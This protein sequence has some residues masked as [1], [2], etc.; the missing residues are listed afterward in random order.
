MDEDDDAETLKHW[1]KLWPAIYR[2][3]GSTVQTLLAQHPELAHYCDEDVSPPYNTVSYPWIVVH[4]MRV[5]RNSAFSEN[6][7]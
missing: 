7:Y 5:H 1:K 6:L 3:E 2:M 4:V